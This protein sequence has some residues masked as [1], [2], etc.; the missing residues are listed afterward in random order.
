MEGDVGNSPNGDRG[1]YMERIHKLPFL[2]QTMIEV[3]PV[4]GFE[5]ASD[6]ERGQIGWKLLPVSASIELAA[7]ILFALNLIGTL[8]QRLAHLLSARPSGLQ[9]TEGPIVRSVV[10]GL[11]S[12]WLLKNRLSHSA[13]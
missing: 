9:H 6:E 2:G 4:T 7:V 12:C 8:T 5:R 13:E 1:R 10:G 3:C 11:F